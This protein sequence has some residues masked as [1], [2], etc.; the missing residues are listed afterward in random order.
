M[1]IITTNLENFNLFR[2]FLS[3]EIKNV[4]SENQNVL[5]N[6]NIMKKKKEHLFNNVTFHTH[7]EQKR[8]LFFSGGLKIKP[9]AIGLSP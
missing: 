3:L 7:N 9:L 8:P 6:N 4:I 5:R 2:K 1:K